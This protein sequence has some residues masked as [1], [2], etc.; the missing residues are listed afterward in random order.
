MPSSKQP[1]FTK[2]LKNFQKSF[3]V[4]K[5]GVTG[6][7]ILIIMANTHDEILSKDCEKDMNGIKA[8][9]KNICEHFNFEF[10]CIEISGRY[11]SWVGVIMALDS[12]PQPHGADAIVFYYTGHGFSY[13][14]DRF[15]KYPQLDTRNHNEQV[16]YN[17]IDFIKNHTVNL[18]AVLNVFRFRGCRVNIAIADCCNTTIPFK[19]SEHSEHD[20][21]LS[22]KVLPS[23]SKTLTRELYTNEENN[24]SIIV[25]SSQFGQPAITDSG[26][27]SIFTN[28]FIQALTS[29]LTDHPKGVPYIPW[30]KIL[31]KA[32]AHAFKE[33]KSYDIGGGIPGKQKAVFQVYAGKQQEK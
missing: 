17:S 4:Q 25:A 8:A 13:K 30:I 18:E 33:S 26:K 31:K 19:R 28:F 16:D 2:V 15:S 12:L 9:F 32:S 21:S 6:R 23:K 27:G 29:I 1:P 10:C 3:S 5:T 24:I 20:M 22:K 11:Y 7:L 14:D